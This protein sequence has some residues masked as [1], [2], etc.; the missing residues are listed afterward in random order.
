MTKT[1]E[2][3]ARQLVEKRKGILAADESIKTMTKRLETVGIKSTLKNR[4]LWRE[5][6]LKTQGIEKFF[7]GVILY[8]ET[9]RT[10]MTD[11]KRIT[12]LLKEKKILAGIKVDEGVYKFNDQGE[13]FTLGLDQLEKRL[14]EYQQMGCVF[15]KWRAVY[16]IN[17]HLPSETTIVANNVGLAQYALIAQKNHFVPIVEP[18]VLV[19]EGDHSIEKSYQIT[20]KVLENLFYW[21]KAF[22]INFKGML[23]KPNMVLAGKNA[24]QQPIVDEVVERT[25]KVLKETVPSDVAG[26]VFLSGG[27]SPDEATDYLR[28]MNRR[29]KKLPWPLSFSFGRALQQEGLK[30][31]EGKKANI[32]KAQEM[33]YR[34]ALKVSLARDGK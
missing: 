33:C 5:I 13:S 2:K 30:A 7:S 12:D 27:L 21:L 14:I 18:E 15:T 16:H 3:I 17:A 9:L 34:R 19:L 23:L 4:C 25:V 8:D 32:K 6:I 20:K 11:G 10:P 29:Y 28:E 22:K 26:I 1:L 31:W 24:K